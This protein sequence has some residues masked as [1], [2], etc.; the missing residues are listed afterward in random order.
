MAEGQVGS[1]A[2]ALGEAVSRPAAQY[3]PTWEEP[4]PG[5]W[6][7]DPG[8]SVIQ[9][10]ARHFMVS[11]VRG[12]FARFSGQVTTGDKPTD[13]RVEAWVDA[14]SLS[15]GDPARDAHLLSADFFAVDRWP[16][17]LLSGQVVESW[18]NRYRLA[19]QMTIRDVTNSVSFD[20]LASRFSSPGDE[21]GR[22]E[23]LLSLLATARVNRKD[24]GLRWT[25]AIETGGVVVADEVDLRLE[26]LARLSSG[27]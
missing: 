5:T 6:E 19:A 27:T 2:D 11:K 12:R 18:G 24:F 17:I 26:V 9:F 10:V 23:M 25:A 7:V 1:E 8:R 3:G 22:P 14:T 21:G 20:V 16:R 15:T 4:P 13:A